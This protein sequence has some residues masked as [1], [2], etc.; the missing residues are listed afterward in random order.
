MAPLLLTAAG[1]ISRLIGFFYRIFLSHSIGAEGMGIFQLISPYS[2]YAMRLRSLASRRLFPK[3]LQ[4]GLPPETKKGARDL[5]IVGSA[6]SF[7]ASI[8]AFMAVYF[9][10]DWFCSVILTEP[11]CIPLVRLMSF[12][13][14][15][16]TLHICITSYYFA[17]KK[18]VI[19]SIEQMLEQCIR[20]MSSWVFFS[21]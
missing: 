16:G 15:F 4:H 13:I 11:R 7:C 8:L 12:T 2:I 9:G 14:P 19:P 20:V 18:T 6:I 17:Q 21:A 10:C 5:F 3:A 1:L